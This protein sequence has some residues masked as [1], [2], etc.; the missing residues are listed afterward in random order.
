MLI[1]RGRVR[2]EIRLS[3]YSIPQIS[4]ECGRRRERPNRF[5]HFYGAG[6]H[7]VVA[8]NARGACRCC[9]TCGNPPSLKFHLEAFAAIV[10]AAQRALGDWI[11]RV[12]VRQA[13]TGSRSLGTALGNGEWIPLRPGRADG[14]QARTVQSPIAQHSSVFPLD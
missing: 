12:P 3:C 14:D 6:I 13:I 1:G 8:R 7:A 11:D 2:N 10:E 4:Y 5:A 9:R